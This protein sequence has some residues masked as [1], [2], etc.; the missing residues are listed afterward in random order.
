MEGE[1]RGAGPAGAEIMHDVSQGQSERVTQQ[2]LLFLSE[3][4]LGRKGIS[5]ESFK[6]CA[7]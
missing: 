5:R 1:I 2:G 3:D 7:E 6:R 4:P